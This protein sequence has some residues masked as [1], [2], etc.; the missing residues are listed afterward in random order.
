MPTNVLVAFL[1]LISPVGSKHLTLECDLNQK[2]FHS[3]NSP[4]FNSVWRTQGINPFTLITD[5]ILY[6]YPYKFSRRVKT[7]VNLTVKYIYII[8]FTPLA[9]HGIPYNCVKFTITDLHV[10]DAMEITV[11]I[12]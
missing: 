12:L 7:G 10:A 1:K 3:Q 9:N 8:L 2:S 6:K 4:H 11:L 5:Q